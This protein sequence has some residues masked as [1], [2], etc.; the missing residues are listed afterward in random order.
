[1]AFG[2]N[3]FFIKEGR[4]THS[5]R[6]EMQKWPLG[7]SERGQSLQ[8]IRQLGAPLVIPGQFR[9]T[10]IFFF[11]PFLPWISS[12]LMQ[13]A[14]VIKENV[15]LFYRFYFFVSSLLVSCSHFLTTSC[16]CA[17]ALVAAAYHFS[18][19]V[20]WWW[21]NYAC[22]L[23]T[24]KATC[25]L[26]WEN[27]Q[28]GDNTKKQLRDK[29]LLP[30]NEKCLRKGTSPGRYYFIEWY[31]YQCKIPSGDWTLG[32]QTVKTALPQQVAI[33]VDHKKQRGGTCVL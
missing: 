14:L 7:R 1:M 19:W 30:Y 8:A 17:C 12:D 3:L 29:E 25:S 26:H 11:A 23:H 4:G 31:R 32:K 6:N 28:Q 21:K 24:S 18:V 9:A 2:P 10:Q 15:C 20:S 16:L 27:L 33:W 13:F 5:C 22:V